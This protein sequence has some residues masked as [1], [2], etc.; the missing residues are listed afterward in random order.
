MILIVQ[1]QLLRK[2]FNG[3]TLWPF[4]VLRHKGQKED[5]VFLNHEKIHLRQQ[6]ELLLVFFYL[7]YGLEFLLRLIQYQNRHEA[8]RNISFEREAYRYESELDYL[9]KRKAYG[10]FKFY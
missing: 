5:G 2:N 3:M 10:F 7:F 9:K 8:Y 4:I 1:P 6:A